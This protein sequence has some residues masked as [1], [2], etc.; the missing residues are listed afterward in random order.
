MPQI[1]NLNPES[2]KPAGQVAAGSSPFGYALQAVDAL[3][4]LDIGDL[5]AWPSC[6]M[7]GL[8]FWA[9]PEP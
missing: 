6:F 1:L 4:D 7:G 3:Q 8:G 9:Q 2:C 5:G